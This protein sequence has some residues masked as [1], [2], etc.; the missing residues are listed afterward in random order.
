M[1]EKCDCPFWQ[2]PCREH[3][4]RLYVQLIGTHPQT[5][6]PVNQWNCAFAWMPA[7]QI[8]TTQQVRQMGAAIES[9]RN[10]MVKQNEQMTLFD[11]ADKNGIKFI[12]DS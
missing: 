5:G 2:G 1:T 3:E 8:E 11:L 12:K 6:Q 9:F 10:E 7:M 4:C